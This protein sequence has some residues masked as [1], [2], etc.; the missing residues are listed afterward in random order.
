[1]FGE[2]TQPVPWKVRVPC[3]YDPFFKCFKA[4]VSIK[5]GQSFKFV[6][7]GGQRYE[8][9][10]RYQRIFDAHGN[11]NNVYDPKQIVW[12]TEKKKIKQ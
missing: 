4:T 3:Q 8:I 10:V 7:N 11:E 1:M 2:F 12:T 5:K 6:I 9:S